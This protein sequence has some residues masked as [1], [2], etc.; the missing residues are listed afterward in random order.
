VRRD[1]ARKLARKRLQMGMGRRKRENMMAR[2][3]EQRRH[4]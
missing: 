1:K 4:L 3:T 2:R